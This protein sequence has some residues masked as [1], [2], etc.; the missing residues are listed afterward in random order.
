MFLTVSL[1]SSNRRSTY[2]DA[3]VADEVGAVC[4]VGQVSLHH[5]FDFSL[6][7][8]VERFRKRRGRQKQST[9]TCSTTELAAAAKVTKAT[10]DNKLQ[11]ITTNYNNSSSGTNNTI[12]MTNIVGK[13]RNKVHIN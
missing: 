5:S 7:Q 11:Q 1:S 10:S 3:R 13:I 9:A 8:V 2:K 12:T 6:P 4:Q